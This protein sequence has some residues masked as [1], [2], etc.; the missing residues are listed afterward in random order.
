MHVIAPRS[1]LLGCDAQDDLAH[2][3]ICPVLRSAVAAP[4]EPSE[5][6]CGTVFLGLGHQ[7]AHRVRPRM[8]CVRAV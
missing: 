2:Y 3:L 6:G 5:L 8:A 4:A 1:C 7:L